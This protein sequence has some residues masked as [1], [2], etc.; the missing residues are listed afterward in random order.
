MCLKISAASYEWLHLCRI[1][2]FYKNA[3]GLCLQ[4]LEAG[5]TD[6]EV[7]NH[8]F[9]AQALR[10]LVQV[11]LELLIRQEEG[12]DK[13]DAGWNVS[14]AAGTCLELVAGTVTDDI[15]PL[16]MPFVQ[17]SFGCCGHKRARHFV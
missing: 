7:V 1:W 11:L 9:V 5:D 6:S 14:M 3:F 16:V 2:F 8:R 17:V 12:Q 10:P 13:D 4:Q 15:V